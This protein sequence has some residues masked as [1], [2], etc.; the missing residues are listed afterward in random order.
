MKDMFKFLENAYKYQE[1]VQILMKIEQNVMFVNNLLDFLINNAIISLKDAYPI[2]LPINVNFANKIIYFSM[3]YAFIMILTVYL[4]IMKGY[5]LYA[6]MAIY[7]KRVNVC[8]IILFVLIMI[9]IILIV[10]K[11]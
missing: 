7:L 1:I 3:D 11:R 8:S 10:L 9:Q 4:M 2:L 6:K 5:V